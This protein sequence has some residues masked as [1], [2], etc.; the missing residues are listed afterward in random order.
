MREY[1]V[2]VLTAGL[3]TYLLTG[4]CRQ[5]ATRLGAV[6]QVRGRDVHT[7]PIPYFGGLAMLGGTLVSAA[8]SASSAARWGERRQTGSVARGSPASAIAWQRQPPKSRSFSSQLRQGSGI[9]S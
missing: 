4:G 7:V 2:V 1:L 8:I 3:T 5:L 6:A 9:Q